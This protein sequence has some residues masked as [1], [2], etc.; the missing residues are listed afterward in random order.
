MHAEV[1]GTRIMSSAPASAMIMLGLPCLCSSLTH[2]FARTRES[3]LVM[4]YTMMAAAA[5]LQQNGHR[6]GAAK[7]L[8]RSPMPSGHRHVVRR[9]AFYAAIPA[10][11]S[12]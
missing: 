1:P 7:G 10:A 6:V 3:T 8:A 9:R 11:S 5:P 4:S 2:A 12:I